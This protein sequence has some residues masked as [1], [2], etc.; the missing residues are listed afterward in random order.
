[1]S[2]K[3]EFKKQYED[4]LKSKI[5][6]YCNDKGCYELYWDYTESISPDLLLQAFRCY[7]ADGYK[8]T[9]EYLESELYENC[10]D[11]EDEFGSNILHDLENEDFYTEEF[12][13][14]FEENCDLYEDSKDCGYNGLDVN[15]DG[16]LK[17]SKFH[18]NIMFATA[19][20]EN[21]DMSSIHYAFCDLRNTDDFNRKF[22][23]SVNY[24]LHQQGYTLKEY[25]EIIKKGNHS[26]FLDSLEEEL[27]NKSYIMSE[28]T[29][30]VEL[31][32]EDALEFL[33]YLGDEGSSENLKLGKDTMFGL[34]NEW[35]GS[36]SIFEIELEKDFIVPKEMIRGVQIEGARDEVSYT[37]DEVYGLVSDCWK[38]TLRLTN[39]EPELQEENYETTKEFIDKYVLEDEEEL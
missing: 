26:K 38:K 1:M 22:D 2:N 29:A 39:E 18:I 6:E 27:N 19:N 8:K 15:L 3:E 9:E 37:V 14:W 33:N 25:F 5:K 28:L 24:L 35:N 16:L 4:F 21:S 31:D 10:L 36:G 34:F 32:G 17:N 23:N 13:E 30:L 7:K 11:C 12:E 20:E